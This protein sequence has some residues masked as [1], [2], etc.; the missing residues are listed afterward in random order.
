MG[1]RRLEESSEL[2]CKL[3]HDE[4]RKEADSGEGQES[5]PCER[6]AGRALPLLSPSCPAEHLLFLPTLPTA[7]NPGRLGSLYPFAGPRLHT[8][9]IGARLE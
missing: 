2:E 5:P 7:E 3:H 4:E 1:L 9:P 8:D 6:P